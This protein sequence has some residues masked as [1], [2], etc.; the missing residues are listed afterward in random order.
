MLPTV[1]TPRGGFAGGTRGGLALLPAPRWRSGGPWCCCP[2]LLCFPS[3]L[4]GSSLNRLSAS[5]LMRVICRRAARGGSAWWL[6]ADVTW[7]CGKG[8]GTAAVLVEQLVAW[9]LPGWSWMSKGSWMQLMLSGAAAPV[10][11]PRGRAETG[12][13]QPC[14]NLCHSL[15]KREA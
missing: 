10:P 1:V 9:R 4:F 5:P 2:G 8:G 3:G 13:A 12:E 15:P 7:S 11:P 14:L 6:F